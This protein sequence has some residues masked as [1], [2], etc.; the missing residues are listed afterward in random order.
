MVLLVYTDTMSCNAIGQDFS[1]NHYLNSVVNE[2]TTMY[3]YFQHN[4]QL[5]WIEYATI[6]I[7]AV[8]AIFSRNYLI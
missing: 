2:E 7:S 6:N 3:A 4:G 5:C 1:I 8:I